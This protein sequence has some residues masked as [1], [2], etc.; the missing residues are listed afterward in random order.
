MRGVLVLRREPV[1]DDDGEHTA[2]GEAAAKLGV[3]LG[4]FGSVPEEPAAAVNEDDDRMRTGARRDEDVEAVL[5]IVEAVARVVG[6]VAE[7]LAA[8][9]ELGALDRAAQNAAG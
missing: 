7:L 8:G 2:S 3:G 5:L 4:A 6:D 1:G 9:G